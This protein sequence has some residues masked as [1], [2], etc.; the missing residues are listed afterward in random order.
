MA[1]RQG[2]RL[3]QQL[4]TMAVAAPQVVLHRTQRS[5][6]AWH[7]GNPGILGEWWMMGAEKWLAM[8]EAAWAMAF[9]SLQ[10]QN[11]WWTGAWASPSRAARPDAL[12]R[13]WTSAWTRVANSGIAPVRRRVQRNLRKLRAQSVPARPSRAR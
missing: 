3:Q 13:E 6:Q 9:D 12:L 11:D 1:T 4:E 5:W 2:R 8:Q 7:D 10:L